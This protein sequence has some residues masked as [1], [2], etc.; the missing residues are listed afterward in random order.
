MIFH[1]RIRKQKLPKKN[2]S[3]ESFSWFESSQTLNVCSTYLT[4]LG[5]I[6][7]ISI[8]TYSSYKLS[9][10]KKN[11]VYDLFFRYVGQYS[12]LSFPRSMSV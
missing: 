1:G 7:G 3:K 2:K 4:R 12:D 9:V 10:L 8:V 11:R 6:G 5:S